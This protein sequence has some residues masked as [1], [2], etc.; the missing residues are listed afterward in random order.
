MG[1]VRACRRE[2]GKRKAEE[3]DGVAVPATPAA[4]TADA[5][6]AD[7][8]DYEVVDMPQHS[9]AVLLASGVP[10]P[11][12]GGSGGNGGGTGGAISNF[13]GFSSRNKP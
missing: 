3:G 13:F 8:M 10:V 2:R 4:A 1:G 11:A 5:G 9:G 7:D 6:T 12:P